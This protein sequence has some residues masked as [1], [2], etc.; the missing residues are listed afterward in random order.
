MNKKMSDKEMKELMTKVADLQK[1]ARRALLSS[2]RT[3]ASA[4]ATCPPRGMSPSPQI[5][6]SLLVINFRRPFQT[7]CPSQNG[8]PPS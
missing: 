8:S 5:R 6:S 3:T 2:S 4:A 1:E 7:G